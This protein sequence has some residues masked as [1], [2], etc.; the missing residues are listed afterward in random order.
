MGYM[1][2]PK[3]RIKF[4]VYLLAVIAG[5]IGIVVYMKSSG[6]LTY[7]SSA[8][9][10]KN[11]IEGYGEKAYLAFFILQL[12][13]V[14]IAPIPS[15]VSAVVGG[16]VFGMM[17]SFLITM[18]AILIGS[19]IV[20]MLGKKFGRTFVERFVSPKVLDKYEQYFSSRKG[21]LL[22]IVLL[23]LP[24]FPDDAMGF[25]AGLSKISL[26]RYVVI[27][28][29]TR[30]WEILAA[31]ALG[32]FNISMP[33]WGWGVMALVIIGIAK[34]SDKLEKR[35]VAAVQGVKGSGRC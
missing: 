23:F 21:E 4:C 8:E 27:M 20:F 22:L 28:L 34:N 3:D 31:S 17:G 24:F 5:L 2:Q 1:N 30:P 32:S 7:M 26:G 15:N 25:V 35:L 9:E 19:A 10:F 18:L 6:I 11:Y 13:S 12:I 16:T 29:L 14:I 33:L